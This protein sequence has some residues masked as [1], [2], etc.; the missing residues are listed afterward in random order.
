MEKELKNQK[1]E[2][3]RTKDKTKKNQKEPL[4]TKWQLWYF[5]LQYLLSNVFS[6]TPHCSTECKH[7]YSTAQLHYFLH[8]VISIT[9]V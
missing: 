9:L 8:T 4:T 3:K 2:L 1:T 7:Y 6:N 5:P